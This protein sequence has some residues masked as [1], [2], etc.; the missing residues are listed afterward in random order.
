MSR[1][2]IAASAACSLLTMLPA[3]ARQGV[4]AA[5]LGE[6]E[7]LL[8]RARALAAD[9]DWSAC[10]DNLDLLAAGSAADADTPEAAFLR[11]QAAYWLGAPE[12]LSL[13]DAFAAA[14]PASPQAAEARLLAADHCFFAHEFG[15]AAARYAAAGIDGLGADRR[16]LYTYRRALSMLRS[17][18]IAGSRPL[19]ASLRHSG[20]YAAPAAFYLA[21]ADYAEG[22]YDRAYTGFKRAAA[23]LADSDA[24]APRGRRPATPVRAKEPPAEPT[25]PVAGYYLA[26]ID[27]LRG[28]YEEVISQGRTL[29]AR[30]PVAMLRPETDRIVGESFFRL[31]QQG[32][33]LP[34][35]EDYLATCDG[36][37]SP[38]AVYAL[39]AIYYGRDDYA[40][41]RRL[42]GTLTDGRDALAQSAYLY[43]GQIAVAEGDDNAA[44]MAFGRACRM[45]FDPAVTEAALYNY[46]AASTRGGKAPFSS[47]APLLEEFVRRFPSSHQAPD[48]ELYL[49][50]SY[51]G[52]G[53]YAEALEAL[54]GIA[55]PDARALA[56]RQKVL[57]TLG[58][59]LLDAGEPAEAAGYLRQ[60]AASRSDATLAL[61]ARLRLADALYAT[62]DY[63]AAR[64]AYDT[65]LTHAP[66]SDNRPLALYGLAY[67]D[68]R[69]GRYAAAAKAFTRAIDSRPALPRA[70]ADDAL[71]R[72]ADCRYY[73]GDHASA[74]ADYSAAVD[75]AAA[76]A[77]YALLRRA[78]MRGLGG[79]ESGKLADLR[80]LR[81]IFPGSRWLAAGI[82]EEGLAY[83]GAG[84]LKE[85]DKTLRDLG[86]RYPDSPEARQGLLRLALAYA[87][88]GD[89]RAAE[90]SWREVIS[91]W[92]SSAEAD[93][94]HEDLRRLCAAEGRLDEYA[95]F[96]ASVKGARQLDADE[97]EQLTYEA[98][99]TDYATGDGSTRRLEQYVASYPDGKYLA[100]A[101]AQLAE[102][103]AE[104]GDHAGAV[105]LADRLLTARP[106]SPQA[107]NTLYLKASSLEQLGA[108]RRRDALEAWQALLGRNGDLQAEA[109]AGI[110]RTADG[111]TRLK[112]ARQLLA[113]RGAT[114]AQTALARCVEAEATLSARPKQA[115]AALREL[116]ADPASEAG[117]RA[118]VALGEHLLA[119]GDTKGALSALTAFTDAGSPHQYW[120]A[121]GYIALAD[122]YAAGGETYLAR[123]YLA[124]LRDNY[125]GSE[126]DIRRMITS[127][128]NKL[129]K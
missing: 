32:A 61:A 91:R 121:R 12:C 74:L 14:W 108:S 106:D 104:A 103:R 112:A 83:T 34:Y 42:L 37:P 100:P 115:E 11:A 19:F 60:A 81:D 17:G 65:Y 86:S 22:D 40:R 102:A 125:P 53:E 47:S 85:A 20:D 36:D 64:S 72:R 118:A 59:K 44:A 6:A 41:A 123:E 25:A 55:R 39:G 105:E 38:S 120:L 87:E 5:P 76:E 46:A 8:G 63:A 75:R 113:T 18:D 71:I 66:A 82:L 128:L 99:A 127:R 84:R 4:P 77:D 122:A 70:L 15:P 129:R 3:A 49:A 111:D 43:L 119:A 78:V 80:R 21:Y 114:A 101:L 1:R 28:R 24:D 95:A 90:K 116:A 67:C 48:V 50:S 93:L 96:L 68:Y 69:A 117:A 126:E 92:P 54:D 124:T 89:S 97:I 30:R 27:F 26:Q 57:L 110:M 16:R 98:A 13:L 33:A 45:N 10:A 56:A 107:Y 29:L 73:S 23:M 2:I 9:G 58:G 35:L 79:D 88:R 94:A 52:R 51:F 109:L 7:A 31:G 62:G